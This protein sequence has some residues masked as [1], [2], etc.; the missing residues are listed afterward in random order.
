MR[1]ARPQAVLD[2]QADVWRH[3]DDGARGHDPGSAHAQLQ[4]PQ[5]G[6][7]ACLNENDKN[8]RHE[9]LPPSRV[10]HVC[11]DCST[12]TVRVRGG[13]SGL[14]VVTGDGVCI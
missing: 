8:E 1:A 10:S 13:V 4:R 7:S 5:G 9:S 3:A 6:L 11:A 14:F 12:D 2:A